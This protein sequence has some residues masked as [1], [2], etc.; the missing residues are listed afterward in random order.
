MMVQA[1]IARKI[2]VLTSIPLISRGTSFLSGKLY[3]SQIYSYLWPLATPRFIL[4]MSA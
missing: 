2:A 1:R 4:S 3:T